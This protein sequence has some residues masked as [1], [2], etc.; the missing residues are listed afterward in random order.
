MSD[1]LQNVVMD[2]L[3]KHMKKEFHQATNWLYPDE[4][5]MIIKQYL[6]G[7][8][9]VVE[10]Q[11]MKLPLYANGCYWDDP[12]AQFESIK[13]I[14]RILYIHILCKTKD[15]GPIRKAIIDTGVVPRMVEL[16]ESKSDDVKEHVIWTLG[17]IIGDSIE[18]RNLVL[19]HSVLEKLIKI[20]PKNDIEQQTTS[21]TLSLIRR[22][23]RT[24]INFCGGKPLPD[25]K[26]IELATHILSITM[27][28]ED[29]ETVNHSC[30]TF[31]NLLNDEAQIN[32]IIN[33]DF[34]CRL[35]ELLDHTSVRTRSLAL[36]SIGGIIAAPGEHA[37]RMLDMNINILKKLKHLITHDDSNDDIEFE[38][39]RYDDDMYDSPAIKR[40]AFWVISNIIAENKEHIECVINANLIPSIIHE[41]NTEKLAISRGA[42]WVIDNITC[43]GTDE[44][45]EFLVNQG[46]IESLCRCFD[47]TI[48]KSNKYLILA[49]ECID[50]ILNVGFKN[51]IGMDI[52]NNIY[53]K[54]VEKAGGVDYLKQIHENQSIPDEIYD[55]ATE[56]IIKYF[57]QQVI[58]DMKK[59]QQEYFGWL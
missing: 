48:V 24:L 32:A 22:A 31:I 45:I 21:K 28:S 10:E 53:A 54:Y 16:I 59:K 50:K 52:N 33:N 29:D 17:I 5:N 43:M 3:I 30:L 23:I 27:K 20:F 49:L 19:S 1:V 40:T 25:R 14:R 12:N 36:R 55:K 44:Q 18:N 58:D 41:L 38:D 11:M 57:G 8:D 7:N 13:M 4:L 6:G 46:V 9:F 42:L 26:Y 15:M 37:H 47:S 39:D 2:P 34:I 35:V 51:C 56:I